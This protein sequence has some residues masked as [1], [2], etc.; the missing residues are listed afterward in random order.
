ML[1]TTLNVSHVLINFH[2]ERLYILGMVNI[3]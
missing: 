1:D 2:K 3:G